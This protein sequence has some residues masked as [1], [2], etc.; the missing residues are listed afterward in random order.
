M[1]IL[2]LASS[3]SFYKAKELLVAC[4][5]IFQQPNV[6]AL[7]KP[8]KRVL[9]DASSWP[10]LYEYCGIE[11]KFM[12]FNSWQKFMYTLLSNCGSLSITID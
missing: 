12:I 8:F 2:Q 6:V 3:W 7:S 10:L 4:L 1:G 5:P 9:L 11:Y